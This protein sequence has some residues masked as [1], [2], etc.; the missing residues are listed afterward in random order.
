MSEKIPTAEEFCKIFQPTCKTWQENFH[1]TMIE[2]AK[3]HIKPILK[4][5]YKNADIINKAKYPGDINLQVDEDS[6]L[7]A[8]PEDLIK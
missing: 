1:Q 5:A 7:N 2:F 3:L 6:I 4:A 8:Y